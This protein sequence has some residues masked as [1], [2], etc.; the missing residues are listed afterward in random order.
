MKLG[1]PNTAD[2]VSE[3]EIATDFDDL[4]LE[5]VSEKQVGSL[6][7]KS[8]QW[9]LKASGQETG[10]F[11][12][13]DLV[14]MV[15]DNKVGPEDFL[16]HGHQGKWMIAGEIAG[17]I[18]EA[19]DD[20]ELSSGT[21]FAPPPTLQ[22]S[23]V[24]DESS[25]QPENLSSAV[26]PAKTET[27]K[28]Q[29]IANRLNAWLSDNVDSV[30][31]TSQATKSE[32]AS[33]A[34]ASKGNQPPARKV[35]PKVKKVKQPREKIDLSGLKKYFDPK[36]LGIIGGAAVI[37]AC[38]F[39]VSMVGGSNDTAIYHRYEEIYAQIL[40]AKQGNPGQIETIAEQTIPELELTIDEL[41]ADGAGA[42]KAA[43]QKLLFAARDCLIPMLENNSADTKRLDERFIGLQKEVAN[44]LGVK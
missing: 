31:E 44:L 35:Q 40:R 29:E 34:P 4:N 24:E 25:A 19:D 23:E 18:P 7:A 26:T 10:P 13:E 9:F 22:Q 8:D 30:E 2:N 5:I 28:K 33:P 20:F 15:A 42:K 38:V 37:V 41:I 6:P 32:S 36:V 17:L 43:K 1:E 14:A 16:R 27:D 3:L 11:P 21:S 12:F 39:L